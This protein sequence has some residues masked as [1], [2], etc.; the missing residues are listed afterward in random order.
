MWTFLSTEK[1]YLA[2]A[3]SGLTQMLILLFCEIKCLWWVKEN[4]NLVAVGFK[5]QMTELRISCDE[6]KDVVHF[7]ELT[8]KDSV[9]FFIQYNLAQFPIHFSMCIWI[10]K[11][12]S[13]IIFFFFLLLFLYS[14]WK[15]VRQQPHSSHFVVLLQ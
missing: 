1:L 4:V 11:Y 7:K 10:C 5:L 15:K 8:R 3:A 12:I 6:D 9:C 2:K 13:F 14:K